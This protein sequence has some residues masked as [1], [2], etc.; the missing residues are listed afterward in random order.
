MNET[1]PNIATVVVDSPGLGA[2]RQRVK[3]WCGLGNSSQSA[4]QVPSLLDINYIVWQLSVKYD[5]ESKVGPLAERLNPTQEFWECGRCFITHQFCYHWVPCLISVKL[6]TL[7]QKQ[8]ISVINWIELIHGRD[9]I[10]IKVN[11]LP[12]NPFRDLKIFTAY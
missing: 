10:K 12:T 5:G 9:N 7:V 1:Q 2:G 3:H 11:L 6:L 4:E 8:N